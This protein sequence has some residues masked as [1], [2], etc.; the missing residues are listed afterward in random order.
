MN[1]SPDFFSRFIP[2]LLALLGAASFYD[3]VPFQTAREVPA[4]AAAPSSDGPN[5]AALRLWEDP[6]SAPAPSPSAD[7]ALFGQVP[8]H[9]IA[10]LVP[11]DKTG[12]SIEWR[13][14]I[15]HAVIAGLGE[16]KF[17]PERSDS[18][19]QALVPLTAAAPE[20]NIRLAAE[21]FRSG[22]ATT[23]VVWVPED[24]LGEKPMAS[25]VE[26][27]PKLVTGLKNS[28]LQV[29]GP[30]SSGSLQRFI[31]ENH[32]TVVDGV[33]SSITFW[34]ATATA[35]TE[36]L[37]QRSGGKD[38]DVHM[39]SSLRQLVWDDEVLTRALW[40]ELCLR[41]ETLEG[42]PQ[43]L[44]TKLIQRQGSHVPNPDK[45]FVENVVILSEMDS[46]YGR[47]V[48]EK[49]QAWQQ[50]EHALRENFRT[51]S[52][53]Y[54][55]GMDGALPR[56]G[57]STQA[58]PQTKLSGPS[59]KASG[60]S[61]LDYTRRLAVRIRSEVPQSYAR[62]RQVFAIGIF[63][64]DVFDKI[65]LIQALRPHFPG[66]IFFTTDLD[67]RL[68]DPGHR[69][70]T[71]NLLVTSTYGLRLAKE[72]Q[73]ETAPFRDNHQTAIFLAAQLAVGHLS[74][75]ANEIADRSGKAF[76]LPTDPL[77]SP[78]R[79]FE[80]GRE[81][82]IEQR[83]STTAN[84]SSAK[85]SLHPKRSGIGSPHVGLVLAAVFCLFLFVLLA[86]LMWGTFTSRRNIRVETAWSAFCRRMLGDT[87]SEQDRLA[88]QTSPRVQKAWVAVLIFVLVCLVGFA[89]W[90]ASRVDGERF[91]WNSGTSIWPALL[92][93]G[94]GLVV[95]LLLIGRCWWVLESNWQEVLE[96]FKLKAEPGLSPASTTTFQKPL[97]GWLWNK[98]LPML[99]LDYTA[100]KRDEKVNAV[101]L[102]YAY[103]NEDGRVLTMWRCFL[104]F[105]VYIIAAI[106]TWMLLS[107]CVEP[108]RG[109][110]SYWT[111]LSL[112]LL[113]TVAYT[114]LIIYVAYN[115]QLLARLIELL[116]ERPTDWPDTAS[117]YI[118]DIQ[119]KPGLNNV[120]E[121]LDIKFI[122]ARSH[123]VNQMIYYPFIA[124][125]FIVIARSSHFDRWQVT[126]SGLILL[127]I[128]A[129]YAIGAAVMLRRAAEAARKEA[130]RHLRA[131]LLKVRTSRRPNP[132]IFQLQEMISY[133]E[134]VRRGAFASITQQP[135][136]T[137]ALL[138]AGSV[139]AVNLLKWL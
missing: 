62:A 28:S 105:A 49:M 108:F 57:A 14:R 115:T 12:E 111:N 139:G 34:S 71:R 15:R 124:L 107:D 32:P 30:W 41:S 65:L 123:A 92:I 94:A 35:P 38:K 2:L 27:L 73:G 22:T 26:V 85:S 114:V 99:Q 121:F 95:T 1:S 29:I 3:E 4:T 112:N 109:A 120:D 58:D 81:Q 103:R 93:R 86:V 64:T 42:R 61:M 10:V 118:N 17:F 69:A 128:H 45:S 53:S 6:L 126:T 127:V 106:L 96:R 9:L 88:D 125:S 138:P 135:W 131:K 7:T 70:F 104:R 20:P 91:I 122:A 72:L 19:R 89:S 56:S 21:S 54:L 68:L 101:K 37:R 132:P 78:P 48:S 82:W 79:V 83:I 11:A 77:A 98:V 97:S 110:V 8:E 74:Y 113:I 23:V 90:D 87:R 133:I 66:A 80:G 44:S 136:V 59:E 16:A 63:G 137:A 13:T 60:A 31:A 134:N 67:A 52:Y 47:V 129:L 25:M 84:F 76:Y 119:G 102:L 100:M 116:T 5:N 51:H 33:F 24:K 117:R 75:Y 55:R 39:L 36:L 40:Q 18:I 46:T 50:Q 130:L 43:A